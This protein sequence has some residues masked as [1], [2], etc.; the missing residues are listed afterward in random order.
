MRISNATVPTKN[1]TAVIRP[2]FMSHGTLEVQN[3]AQTRKFFEELLGLE[4]VRHSKSSMAVRCGMKFH[5]VCV[6][7][8]DTIKPQSSTHHW[9]LDV[10]T[11][12]QVDH[13]WKLTHQ[14]KD[15]YKIRQ[16]LDTE[17]RH[18]VYSFYIE[19]LDYNWWEIQFYDGV[20]HEDM[21]DFGDRFG[22]A[23]SDLHGS[24]ANSK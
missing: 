2:S 15:R 19:D 7:V 5:I 23:D 8:G 11:K 9:G 1:E 18:G 17:T 14:L 3:L 24:K 6:E 4:C 20:Q 10:D 13:A 12:E 16:I 21:F 22:D